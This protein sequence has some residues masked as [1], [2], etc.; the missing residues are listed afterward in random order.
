MSDP[1]TDEDGGFFTP[2]VT[3]IFASVGGVLALFAICFCV[4]CG[5]RRRGDK[6]PK[7]RESSAVEPVTAA[8]KTGDASDKIWIGRT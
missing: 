5:L 2:Q 1:P 4:A 7:A 3:T 8:S 6:G